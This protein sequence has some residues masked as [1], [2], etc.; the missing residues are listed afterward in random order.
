MLAQACYDEQRYAD[1]IDLLESTPYFVNWE[2]QSITWDIFHRS[3][4]K[5][6]QNRFENKDFAGAA[7]DFEAAVTYPGNIGVGRSN[8]PQEATAEYWR[9]KAL[10]ALGRLEEAKS[11]WKKGAAGKEGSDEQNR[12]RQLCSE[13]LQEVR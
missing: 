6:G 7:K 1:A 4:M 8:R 10:Q 2:G 5:R 3:H 11:A 9:G 12:H 13:A